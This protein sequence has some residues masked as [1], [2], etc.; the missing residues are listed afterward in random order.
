M[1]ASAIPWSAQIKSVMMRLT[2]IVMWST[3]SRSCSS[4]IKY[5]AHLIIGGNLPKGC[6][7]RLQVACSGYRLRFLQETRSLGPESHLLSC[8][9]RLLPMS[10]YEDWAGCWITRYFLNP[11][12]GVVREGA[13]EARGSHLPWPETTCQPLD[14]T[15]CSPTQDCS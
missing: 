2:L 11:S 6:L 14:L 7:Q 12:E 15:C 1:R 9:L 10:L 8:R 13:S 3:P 5:Y 4:D